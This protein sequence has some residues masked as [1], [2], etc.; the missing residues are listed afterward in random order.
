M[1]WEKSDFLVRFLIL[2]ETIYLLIRSRDG[3]IYDDSIDGEGVI[4]VLRE[5]S[6]LLSAGAILISTSSIAVLEP[7]LPL[8]LMETVKPEV[9]AL[10]YGLFLYSKMNKCCRSG[11]SEQFSSRTVWAT[12]SGPIFAEASPTNLDLG[13]SQCLRWLLS[14]YALFQ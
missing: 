8:W 3:E 5:Q 13:F 9:K 2:Q 14:A 6:L 1:N 10:A 12:W 11:S 4:S 7:C